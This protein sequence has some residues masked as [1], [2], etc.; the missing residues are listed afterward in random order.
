MRFSLLALKNLLRRRGRTALTV[1]GVAVAV[2]VL[3]SMLAFNAGY[4]SQLNRE[5][6]GLGIQVLAVPKGCPYEAASLIIHGGVIPKYL[7]YD[8]LSSVQAIDGIDIATPMLLQQYYHDNQPH[9]VYGISAADMQ[10]LKP[11]RV[12]GR[13]FGQDEGHAL[14]VGRGVAEKENLKLGDIIP[15]G[16][17]QEP[18]T[19]VGILEATGTEDDD[20]NF[21]PIAEAQRVFDRPGQM[22]AVAIK[23]KDISQ[24]AAISARLEE[25][26]DI[27]T[28]TMSQVMG[29]ILNLVGSARTLLTSVIVVAVVIS[30][31]GIMNTLLMSVNER[32]QEFGMMKAVGAS[33]W[34]IG[35][36]I[37]TETLFITVGG[38]LLGVG[39]S[40]IGSSLVEGFVRGII[41]YS[42]AGRLITFS[43]GLFGLCLA[44]SVV[45]GL[46]C[47]LYPAIKSS[48][49]TPMEAIRSSFE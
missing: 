11:W 12:E 7:S 37:L 48:R 17:A 35:R 38:G 10:R 19:I 44:F 3:F 46:L 34:D 24:T 16:P 32:R 39:L 14:V 4:S 29:T 25:I 2:A 6:E 5:L 28:V 45:I 23:L 47:G 1:M 42:P 9:I 40:V 26:P 21:L 18:F 13:F 22:T 27:Q 49:L 31:M 30:A 8:D 33:G 43:P 41:P 20:F 36:L 15:F